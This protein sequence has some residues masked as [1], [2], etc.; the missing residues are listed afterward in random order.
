[1]RVRGVNEAKWRGEEEEEVV[2]QMKLH[3]KDAE[4]AAQIAREEVA[5][6]EQG[7][8]SKVRAIGA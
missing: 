7:Q 5:K 8:R 6:H 2:K 1:M 4:A 3:R